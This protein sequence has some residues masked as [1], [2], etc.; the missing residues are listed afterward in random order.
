MK[1]KHKDVYVNEKH[2]FRMVVTAREGW[3]V[4][5]GYAGYF[6]CICNIDFLSLAVGC[7]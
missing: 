6:Y 4:D 3:L 2:K 7:F 5:E 1:R